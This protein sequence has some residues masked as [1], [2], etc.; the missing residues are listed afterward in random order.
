[1]KRGPITRAKRGGW[2]RG[3]AA[4]LALPLA[5]A[6][7]GPGEPDEGMDNDLSTDDG[8]RNVPVAHDNSA[9]CGENTA[10]IVT[11]DRGAVYVFCTFDDG[12][13]GV[14]EELGD[15]GLNT[16]LLGEGV[17]PI[18]LLL[19]VV[20]AGTD[21]PENVLRRVALGE[22]SAV[23]PPPPPFVTG[24]RV[25]RS[26]DARAPERSVHAYCA[27]GNAFWLDFLDWSSTSFPAEFLASPPAVPANCVNM[28]SYASQG[29]WT[30][31]AYQWNGSCASKEK[32]VSCN[33]QTLFEATR[34]EN[35]SAPWTTSLSYWVGSN[36][37]AIWKMYA[38]N[39]K[40]C[41]S[42]T[43]RDDFRYEGK[44]EPG[45][46]HRFGVAFITGVKSQAGCVAEP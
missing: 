22:R 31:S 35:G 37:E 17:S 33:G 21:V 45:A 44:S 30:T 39:Q 36:G 26:P 38:N 15:S 7:L 9:P 16:S 6:C 5:A 41:R 24:K 18:E 34:R 32:I 40:S 13:V 20:P 1:M 14:L 8:P 3:A 28:K 29:T 23:V 43:D 27:S 10:A 25:V 42:G 46:Y 2:V 11:D 4:L 12:E 19:R